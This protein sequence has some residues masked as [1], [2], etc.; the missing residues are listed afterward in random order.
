MNAPTRPA[1]ALPLV[2]AEIA[3]N[4]REVFRIE[5]GAFKGTTVVSPAFSFAMATKYARLRAVWRSSR[6]GASNAA[7]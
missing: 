5:L 1:P 2:V 6:R 3:K 7:D 4:S